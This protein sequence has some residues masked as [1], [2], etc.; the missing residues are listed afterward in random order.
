MLL[1]STFYKKRK[2]GVP[3]VAQWKRIQLGT[4][5]LRVPSLASLSGLRIQ[6][7]RELW[8]GSQLLTI[9][10]HCSCVSG[11]CWCHSALTLATSL[12]WNAVFQQPLAIFQDP[13]Q[14]LLPPFPNPYFP[15]LPLGVPS[16]IPS[17]GF[18][19]HF[20]CLL[21]KIHHF[22]STLRPVSVSFFVYIPRKA[23]P[24]SSRFCW[25]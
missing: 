11:T 6:C 22:Y 20:T 13:V 7:H 24:E 12:D 1:L 15:H 8:C 2:L 14:M 21:K 19:R 17:L 9:T 23:F 3:V 18:L 16:L 5:T 4:T 10:V 25:V